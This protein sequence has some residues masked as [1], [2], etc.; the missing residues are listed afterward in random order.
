VVVND[1]E[2]KY[3]SY[4]GYGYGYYDDDMKKENKIKTIFKKVLNKAAF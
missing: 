2:E 4:G 1:I 3:L